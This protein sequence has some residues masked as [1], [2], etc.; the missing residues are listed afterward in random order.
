MNVLF[1]DSSVPDFQVFVDSV[2][3]NTLP[4]LYDLQTKPEW[5]LPETSRMG[6]VFIEGP[7]Q[8]FGPQNDFLV[9]LIQL[10]SIKHIDFL[11][12]NTLPLWQS[13]YDQLTRQTGVVVGAS[14]NR[15]GNLQYGGD[16]TM[17]STG[18]DIESI[19]FTKS[20]EYYK[21]LLDFGNHNLILKKDGTVLVTGRNGYGQLGIG[22]NADV[23]TFR[24]AT[25]MSNIIAIAGGRNHSV[26][27]K[28]DGTVWATGFNNAGQ[29]GIGT[30][31]DTN[32]FQPAT[33]M[34][35]ITAISTGD[36][37]TL[38]LKNDGTVLVTGYNNAGQLGIGT[39]GDIPS[40][41]RP[42]TNMSNI[43]AIA[44]GA[45]HSVALKNDGTVLVTGFNSDG[46]LGIGTTSNVTTFR[47]AS[48]MSNISAI[49]SGDSYILALKKDGTI[50]ASGFNNAGQLGIGISGA[51][52]GQT[53]FR[54]STNMSN[55]LAIATGDNHSLAL[56]NDG[57][58]LT[59]GYNNNGQ[60]GIGTNGAGTE[61]NTFRP[62]TN[63]SN[64]VAIAGGFYHSM[65]LKKDGTILTT[66]YN[67]Y[68][69]LGNGTNSD[70][71][72]FRSATNVSNIMTLSST[73]FG[74]PVVTSIYPLSGSANTSISI[75]GN[76]LTNVSRILF[77]GISVIPTTKSNQIV[78][79]SV[80]VYKGSVSIILI[81]TFENSIVY[82]TQFTYVNANQPTT[83]A[84][85]N[86]NTGSTDINTFFKN[87]AQRVSFTP[88]VTC[89][90][91]S[92]LNNLSIYKKNIDVKMDGSPDRDMVITFGNRKKRVGWVAAG[93]GTNTL[94]YSYD[95]LTWTAI[96]NSIFTTYGLTIGYNGT[97]WSA[98]GGG[99]NSLAYSYDG[100]QWTGLG[101]STFTNFCHTLV[102]SQT[103]CVAGGNGTNCLAYSYDGINW[104]GLGQTLFEYVWGISC[105]EYLWIAVG[106]SINSMAYS[107][108]GINWIPNPNYYALCAVG[109]CATWN[110]S[111]WV[112]GGQGTYPLTYSYDGINWTGVN[113]SGL[114]GQVRDIAWNG[115]LWVAIGHTPA[116]Q[117]TMAVYSYDGKVWK[118]SSNFS[119]VFTSTTLTGV[120]WN[121]KMF[122]VMANGT[123]T[124]GYSY[125]GI[126]WIG[127]G[128]TIFNLGRKCIHSNRYEN[129]IVVKRR[130]IVAG[131]EGTHTLAYSTDG[132]QWTGLGTSLFATRCYG[133]GY[134]GRI[135]VAV[136]TGTNTIGWSIDALTWYPVATVNS[137]F[138]TGLCISWNGKMW[139]AG[140]IG[141]TNIL[142]SY[143]GI[144]WGASGNSNLIMTSKVYSLDWNGT[145]WVAVGEGTNS[146]M[147]SNNG[148]TWTPTTNLFSITGYKVFWN[149]SLFVA[150]GT[151]GTTLAYSVDGISWSPASTTIDGH[152]LAWNGTLWMTTEGAYSY[153]AKT[154]TRLP[155]PL[156][157]FM[158][159]IWTGSLWLNVGLGSIAYS[160]N[161]MNW[162]N[163][164][165]IVFTPATGYVM[166][167]CS[168]L[169]NEYTNTKVT[170]Q[171]PVVAVGSAPNSIAYS[172]DGIQWSGLGNSLFT[173]GGFAIAYNGSRWVAGGQ[174][175]HTLA[176][177][178]DGLNWIGLGSTLFTTGCY[179]I[180]YNGTLWV[181]VGAGTNTIAYSTDGKRWTPYTNTLFTIANTVAWSGTKWIVGGN[182]M[183]TSTDGKTWTPINQNTGIN[184][185]IGIEY[186]GTMWLAGGL[187][188][189]QNYSVNGLF[190]TNGITFSTG[191]TWSDGVS[192]A[193]SLAV[194]TV[195]LCP[196]IY[197]YDGVTW[198]QST[199]P[200]LT[201]FES[202]AWNGTMW[203]AVGVGATFSMTYSYDGLNWTGI[204]NSYAMFPTGAVGITWN[205]LR[206]IAVGNGSATDSMAY[207]I[208]GLNWIK[209]GKSIMTNGYGIGPRIFDAKL[210]MGDDLVRFSTDSY[211]P[212]G[213]SNLSI[214][215]ANEYNQRLIDLTIISTIIM[216]FPIAQYYPFF[217]PNLFFIT[218]AILTK[219]SNTSYVYS[220]INSLISS[221]MTW[222]GL[223]TFGTIDT[224]SITTNIITATTLALSGTELITPMTSTR[225]Y[226]VIPMSLANNTTTTY[227]TVGTI[228]YTIVRALIPI[229]RYAGSNGLPYAFSD[230]N[231]SLPVGMWFLVG[232]LTCTKT[233]GQLNGISFGITEPANPLVARPATFFGGNFV[234]NFSTSTQ[235][236]QT[237]PF[238]GCSMTISNVYTNN[239][240]ANQTV[241][242][243]QFQPSWGWE[244]GVIGYFT[245]IRIG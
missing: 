31:V 115:T 55:I 172:N 60:L 12:C 32:L 228:G 200:I 155:T 102:W 37:H 223:N 126:R 118:T 24:S 82:P 127:L 140:G 207:S 143:D 162:T 164:G 202:F 225:T 224:G 45:Y 133:I 221:I 205:G 169:F 168:D 136:G 39:S 119:A 208:D 107:Y 28:N 196:L 142:Y 78:N 21:Y 203:I 7:N 212:S 173:G 58:V 3:S 67:G 180:A 183:A 2:N 175:T 230:L 69:Q 226:P 99:T 147:Y 204:P 144:T 104:T 100:I 51:G 235:N 122:V 174:G 179:E 14:N 97:I 141:T 85:S 43:I 149:G 157:N 120:C 36:G 79:V 239:T 245:A 186:N 192:S 190:W 96:G 137:S 216:M 109:V 182:S 114:F 94:A 54:Y 89:Q 128:S 81:D 9:S 244:S 132:I 233:F 158:Y 25:N 170:L 110:G 103:M 57:T 101:T 227:G 231:L 73:T 8:L 188:S 18:Q 238:G 240:G 59:T 150:G 163:L 160:Y 151:G 138:T 218:D 93:E 242:L 71:N 154:W 124:I 193:S 61:V 4:I 26:A 201:Q 35:N 156:S 76:A 105:N 123:N 166:G 52:T 68:G 194:T 83:S 95:G 217:F 161:G 5:V 241:R 47:P 106:Q 148:F 50:L 211:Y 33:N 70:V 46:Q 116:P 153:D 152:G 20:I 65:V 181:A 219:M 1:I 117:S 13:Y 108:D 29:V 113:S 72:T 34:S 80:P 90:S 145:V 220:S 125:D 92:L 195:N 184:V 77:N 134:N 243:F 11:A 74:N 86:F 84:V 213:Y 209:L 222:T 215:I 187:S 87:T 64:I 63:M 98:G 237:L 23:N 27:L 111:M 17:E 88:D 10:Y 167:A 129:S 191:I 236:N 176:Y 112:A 146:V 66:G 130:R 16:W 38:A 75:T 30:Y 56:K 206:W 214:G 42:A 232:E 234:I 159:V 197:S 91:K 53:T 178:D 177:S 6:I 22:T 185:V 49:A 139:L 131:G 44:G 40:T 171:T 189:N 62:T 135:W 121:G 15:T 199:N 48:N 41:F 229:T 19:Y 198:V 165:P 210:G